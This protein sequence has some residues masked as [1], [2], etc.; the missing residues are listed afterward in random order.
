MNF[1]KPQIEILFEDAWWLVVNKPPGVMSQRGKRLLPNIVDLLKSPKSFLSAAHRLDTNVS[2][3]LVLAKTAQSA[4]FFHKLL[5]E[6]RVR[7]LY[8][9]IL[10][11]PFQR[12]WLPQCWINAG[13]KQGQKLILFPP[14]E[15]FTGPVK[16]CRLELSPLR[17]VENNL[18]A[19][20]K[21]HTG[22]FHQ[23]RAQC[24]F[25]NCPILGDTKYGGPRLSG[26]R[27]ALHATQV[28][29]PLRPGKTGH[30]MCAS[31]PTWFEEV[32]ATKSRPK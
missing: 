4:R 1:E 30:T 26:R 18:L 8:R 6:R 11:N 2:G 25:H 10:S 29:F 9:A 7:K 22:V 14:F 24:A 20:I 28:T 19:E 23:I 27:L 15:Q 5:L 12:S 16:S 3:V 31:E 17:A 21:L 13:V 32:L